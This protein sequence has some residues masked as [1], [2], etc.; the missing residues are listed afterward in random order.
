MP[1]FLTQLVAVLGSSAGST[2]EIGEHAA[3]HGSDWGSNRSGL[4]LGLTISRRGV[5]ACGGGVRVRDVPGTECIF[6][7]DLPREPPPAV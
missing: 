2:A 7:V 6:T 1:L 3:R 4:G 5:E